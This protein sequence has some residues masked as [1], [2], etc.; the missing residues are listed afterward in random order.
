MDFLGFG[1]LSIID[2][3]LEQIK[4]N[5]GVEI[6]LDTIDLEDKETYEML[7]KGNTSGVSIRIG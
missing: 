4:R 3:T 6:D 5:H 1:T 7:G 2:N